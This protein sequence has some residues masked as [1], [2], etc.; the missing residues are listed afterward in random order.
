MLNGTAFRKPEAWKI[1]LSFLVLFTGLIVIFKGFGSLRLS[2]LSIWDSGDYGSIIRKGYLSDMAFP[3]DGDRNN[4]AFFPLYPVLGMT[5]SFITRLAPLAALPIVSWIGAFFFF[6]LFTDLSARTRDSHD[7]QNRQLWG[8]ILY[9]A[10][11]FLFVGYS[12][13]LYCALLFWAIRI[14]FVA[15]SE[16][17]RLVNL[18]QI[19]CAGFLVGA[20]RLTGI[21]IPGIC[22]GLLFLSFVLTKKRD[23]KLSIHSGI[24]ALS[25]LLGFSSFL[26]YCHL[27]F[28][29]W[30]LY[31]TTVHQ[32]WNK[33]P[34]VLNFLRL[35]FVSLLKAPAFVFLSTNPVT[36]SQIIT[37]CLLLI[38]PYL[39]VRRIRNA[40]TNVTFL[41]A[42]PRSHEILSITMMIAGV[43][44]LLV[45]S[46]ADS[47]TSHNWGN[48]M[49]YSAPAFYL[50]I[51]FGEFSGPSFVTSLQKKVNAINSFPWLK[52]FVVVLIFM[53]I[54]YMKKFLLGRWVS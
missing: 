37:T 13:S 49:R 41:L 8:A 1:I 35:F 25:S 46:Y 12:E 48:G 51:L 28:G 23:P 21:V 42:E 11:F 16:K 50:F 10:T 53:Q 5:V 18:A 32:V 6:K 20:T 36:I 26:I 47:G 52:A 2:T 39:I 14:L 31:F 29:A 30:D 54:L 40:R 22:F 44:H 33:S 45:T 27:K 43:V 7:T 9:P 17:I 19:F 34:S 4:V 3:E 15:N 24:W 38:F